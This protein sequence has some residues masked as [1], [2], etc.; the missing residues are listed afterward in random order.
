MLSG[1]NQDYTTCIGI[2]IMCLQERKIGIVELFN[3]FMLGIG[4]DSYLYRLLSH[5]CAL[6]VHLLIA[7]ERNYDS[8]RYSWIP[9]TGNSLD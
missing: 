1:A 8:P 7:S 5:P 6:L 3:P 2:K 4:G 9:L